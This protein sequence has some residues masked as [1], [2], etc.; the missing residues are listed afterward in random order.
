MTTVY[1]N[2]QYMEKKD[3]AVSPDDRGFL[4]GDGAYE[5]IRSYPGCGLFQARPHLKRLQRSIDELKIDYPSAAALLE[6][7][8]NLI[9]DNGLTGEDAV[10]YLQV[11]RGAAKRKHAFPEKGTP[12]TVYAS[13]SP[14]K[15]NASDQDRGTGVNLVPDIRWSRCD[16]KSLNL[17]PNVMSN[18]HAKD[19]GCGESLF[20]RDGM[21]TEGTHTNVCAV[22]DGRVHT[23][24]EGNHILAGITREV[25][26]G[27]CKTLSIPVELLAVSSDGLKT[28]DE[29]FLTGT[30]A[31]ITPVV[32]VDGMTVGDGTPG[33]VTRKLQ[34]AY[35]EML[36]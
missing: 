30:T 18:Q 29:V 1:L 19:T 16:I 27:I 10:V 20:V 32:T 7:A 17:I 28:A 36:L 15:G 21:V 25:V 12:A 31:E 26:L 13:A 5:V 3:A 22:F 9:R 14:F 11:T 4:F 8:E 2:G 24:P 6:V 35:M 33:P 23:H 34:A